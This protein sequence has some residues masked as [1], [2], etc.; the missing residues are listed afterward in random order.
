MRTPAALRKASIS[1]TLKVDESARTATAVAEKEKSAPAIQRTTTRILR[2]VT[3]DLFTNDD[4]RLTASRTKREVCPRVRRHAPD[5]Q[6]GTARHGR[7]DRSI[8]GFCERATG[9]EWRA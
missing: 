5:A 3:S 8:A 1:N 6:R 4:V 2:W 7:R 9:P